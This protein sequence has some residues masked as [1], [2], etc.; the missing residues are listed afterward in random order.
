MGT[1]PLILGFTLVRR[2][3]LFQH[4]EANIGRVVDG[5]RG[6]SRI[7]CSQLY[8]NLSLKS[9]PEARLGAPRHEVTGLPPRRG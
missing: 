1:G 8:G 2:H 6:M 5:S 3:G 7:R 4:L 9:L